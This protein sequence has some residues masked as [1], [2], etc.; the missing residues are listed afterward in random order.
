MMLDQISEVAVEVVRFA[1]KI[2]PTIL[3]DWIW[4][5][6]ERWAGQV[7]DGSKRSGL[8]NWDRITSQ[9]CRGSYR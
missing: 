3:T 2:N 6:S 7:S 1:L 4:D 8:R 5:L 9:L